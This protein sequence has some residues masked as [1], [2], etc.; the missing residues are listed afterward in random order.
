MGLAVRVAYGVGADVVLPSWKRF[1]IVEVILMKDFMQN[2]APKVWP[3]G[4]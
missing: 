3:V 2:V 1:I 4:S